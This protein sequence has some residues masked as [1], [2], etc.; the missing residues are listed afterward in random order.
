MNARISITPQTDYSKSTL[1]VQ[2]ESGKTAEAKQDA[3]AP[4]EVSVFAND[5]KIADAVIESPS[6]RTV[7]A[8]YRWTDTRKQA[9]SVRTAGPGTLDFY[10]LE[11]C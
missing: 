10:T 2:G 4:C 9:L 5:E 1:P 3:A 11:F 8:Q 6:R 7:A